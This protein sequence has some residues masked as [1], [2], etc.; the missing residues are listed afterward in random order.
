MPRCNTCRHWSATRDDYTGMSE[1]RRYPPTQSKP[2]H[3]G[4]DIPLWPQTRP[5]DY[6]GEHSEPIA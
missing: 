1:C 6:C 2:H 3:R 4:G 5:S